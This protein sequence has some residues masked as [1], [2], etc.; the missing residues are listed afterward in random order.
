MWYA[1][2]YAE[3]VNQKIHNVTEE[4]R[5]GERSVTSNTVSV[6]SGSPS[7]LTSVSSVQFSRSRSGTGPATSVTAAS[8]ALSSCS[9]IST[10]TTTSRAPLPGENVF[11]RLWFFLFVPVVW[12]DRCDT[13]LRSRGRG[14]G[15]GRKR[16]GTGRRPGR[17][18]K[19]IRLGPP[20]DANGDKT[21]VIQSFD[22]C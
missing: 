15:R 7:S 17:P 8:W 14:R 19:F 3:F 4:E 20:V 13:V 22:A 9:C 6:C 11:P 18:P 16:F 1:A 12:P 21:T 5:K 2:A 10:C